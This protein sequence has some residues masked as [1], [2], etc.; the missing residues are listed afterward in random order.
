M[1]HITKKKKKD[2]E[3]TPIY[4]NFRLG[5]LNAARGVYTTQTSNGVEGAVA[6]NP[7]GVLFMP[8]SY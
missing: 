3:N 7:F 8:V 5:A 6:T 4:P 2:K 1:R